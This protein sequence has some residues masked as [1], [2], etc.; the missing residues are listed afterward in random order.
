MARHQACMP[1]L[2]TGPPLQVLFLQWQKAVHQC[3]LFAQTGMM[4]SSPTQTTWSAYLQSHNPDQH[5]FVGH[6]IHNV[7]PIRIP[8]SKYCE[9]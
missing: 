4:T 5:L 1:C 6:L 8:W 9:C 2:P 7:G 3:Q